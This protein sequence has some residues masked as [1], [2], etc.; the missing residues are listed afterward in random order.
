MR[1]QKGQSGNPNGRPKKDQALSD[2][3][4]KK[5]TDKVIV[6]RSGKKEKVDVKEAIVLRVIDCAVR[7]EK[8]AIIEI[9]DRIEG[10]AK[11]F[12][13]SQ[14][15]GDLNVNADQGIETAQGLMAQLTKTLADSGNK[16]S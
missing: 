14:L 5:L 10:K 6:T 15:E 9:W 12:V 7:G 1:F 13:D 16:T 8:W 2:L 4:R 3:L 11:Q